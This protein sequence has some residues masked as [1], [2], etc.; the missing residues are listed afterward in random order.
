MATDLQWGSTYARIRVGV[1][2]A[3]SAGPRRRPRALLHSHESD[4]G[5]GGLRDARKGRSAT[6]QS[7]RPQTAALAGAK[8]ASRA[9]EHGRVVVVHCGHASGRESGARICAKAEVVA[10]ADRTR[11]VDQR[12]FERLL[13]SAKKRARVVCRQGVAVFSAAGKPSRGV[14]LTARACGTLRP[15]APSPGVWI[16]STPRRSRHPLSAQPTRDSAGRIRD[17]SPPTCSRWLGC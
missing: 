2:E 16:A 4:H 8:R 12:A 1:R 5:R 3:K 14:A 9:S 11:N 13:P 7:D 17:V 10:V 6:A 15:L